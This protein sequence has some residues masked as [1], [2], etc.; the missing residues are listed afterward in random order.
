[1]SGDRAWRCALVGAT[2]FALSISAMAQPLWI[3][4]DIVVEG[5]P[6]F[7][8]SIPR[9]VW[10]QDI[11]VTAPPLAATSHNRRIEP[12]H[13]GGLMIGG[14]YRWGEW[15][16]G[17]GFRSTFSQTTGNRSDLTA[18]LSP[19][20]TFPVS[21]GLINIPVF[22]GFI[23]IVGLTAY[24][25]TR[26]LLH[27]ADLEIGYQHSYPWGE[28]RLFGGVRYIDYDAR[29]RT[30]FSTL[31]LVEFDVIRDG[32]YWGIGPRLGLGTTLPLSSRW[33]LSAGLSGTVL[34]GD[35]TTEET[36][37]VSVPP[38]LF[39][40]SDAEQN[41]GGRTV[42]GF[43]GQ[44]SLTYL[45]D[46][47]FYASLGYGVQS[48]V[49]L[50]D[51]RR[52]D[53]LASIQAGGRVFDGTSAGS[54]VNH[55]PFVRVGWRPGLSGPADRSG[56]FPPQNP[57][58]GTLA[59]ET[60]LFPLDALHPGQRPHDVSF[61]G[62]L[63]F[64]LDFVDRSR[65]VI[66]PFFRYDFT[67]PRRTHWDL[68]EAYWAREFEHFRVR[69]GV[70]RVFWGTA[71]SLRLVDVINQVDF[72]ETVSPIFRDNRLGQPLAQVSFGQP[73]GNV[74]LF[75][76]PYARE[77]TFP[78]RRGR[79]RARVEVDTDETLFESSLGHWYPSFA[80]R[81]SHTLGSVDFGLHFF[82][83]TSRDPSIIVRLP[84]PAPVI[85]TIGE[86]RVI[87]LYKIINQGGIDAQYTTGPWQFKFEGLVREGQNNRSGQEET[88]FAF[89][90][91]LE[92]T[93]R[94]FFGTGWD[95]GVL[96]EFLYDNRNRR[97]TTPFERDLFVGVRLALNDV[98]DTR[99]LFGYFQDVR[100]SDK[101]LFVE[102]SRRIGDHLRLGAEA[103]FF[104][105][106]SAGNIF[107]DIR[108]DHHFQLTLAYKF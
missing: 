84:L 22:P 45:F 76:L 99:A 64:T 94:T 100:D 37:T 67:D 21:P 14:L 23:P 46:S 92:Y 10:A 16:V 85:G 26:S 12:E 49:G 25:E 83:G 103:R 6:S 97:A 8:T 29:I 51:T 44:V 18:S 65:I 58:H 47:R 41:G 24:T 39:T 74:D 4:T 55:G 53:P 104:L 34:F 5:S 72:V 70:A 66:H 48:Y 78:G 54:I 35:R 27:A 87:P 61:W 80:A 30:R 52:L 50:N 2:L 82:H 81:Y 96:A 62:D 71:E 88:Y 95:V 36:R 9:N 93:F 60:R 19:Q 89:V 102:A 28:L 105:N 1:M 106:P 56:P 38:A 73:W 31:G 108:R 107:Y 68:R 11:T 90:G 86:V 17:A 59:V 77:R 101:F 32:S 3:G 20:I 33:W 13:G 63:D 15:D 98:D 69:F 43:D 42:F 57:I 40:F 91:G 79:L 75:Y 7:I